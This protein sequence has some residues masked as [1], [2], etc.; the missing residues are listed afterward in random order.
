MEVDVYNQDGK[1]TGTAEL[2]ASVFGLPWNAGL[3]HQVL[4]GQAANRRQP[5][6]HAK[7]RGEVRG[8]GR[9]PWRQK[10][11]GRARHGS[12]RSPIWK[13]GGVTH[14]PTKER[15]F[16]KKVNKKMAAKALAMVLSAKVRDK[17]LLIVDDLVPRL[18]KTKDAARMFENFSK[19]K[20]F[21]DIVG[22]KKRTIALVSDFKPEAKR[23]LKNLSYLEL[24]EARNV[25]ALD[26]INRKYLVAPKASVEVLVKRL[27][28]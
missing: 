2:S 4:I 23:S 11:T 12:I 8:G 1:K 3:A 19:I 15:I 10:G 17:E 18:F 13:G 16:K 24:E 22:K 28:L 14:G 20:G 9:K 25:T 26:V 21:G 27:G 7:G 5:V 6:A